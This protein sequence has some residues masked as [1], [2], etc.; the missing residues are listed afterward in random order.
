MK[1]RKNELIIILLWNMNS[2]FGFSS[3][4]MIFGYLKNYTYLENYSTEKN[5][6]NSH[7]KATQ[8][9]VAWGGVP[10]RAID[11]NTN[12]QWSAG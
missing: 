2:N 9:T 6:L 11:G 1:A 4:I 5:I 3:R 8:N 12:G 10:S 7:M